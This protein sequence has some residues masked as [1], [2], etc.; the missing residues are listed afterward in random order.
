M[1]EIRLAV[2]AVLIAAGMALG[3]SIVSPQ[4][5]LELDEE[6][7]AAASAA[8]DP[9]CQIASVASWRTHGN[10]DWPITDDDPSDGF[11]V[12]ETRMG[13]EGGGVEQVV[14]TF[15]VDISSSYTPGQIQVDNG[16]SVDSET[17][18]PD[19]TELTIDV[20]GSVNI[21]AYTFDLAGSVPCLVGPATFVIRACECNF[22]GD[23]FTNNI[24]TSQVRA[25]RCTDPGP[26]TAFLDVIPDGHT[27][28]TDI[29]YTA[30]SNGTPCPGPAVDSVGN[31]VLSVE[32]AGSVYNAATGMNEIPAEDL[33]DTGDGTFYVDVVVTS[34]DPVG[35]S[36]FG[37]T[38]DSNPE[39]LAYDEVLYVDYAGFYSQFSTRFYGPEPGPNNYWEN[40][41]AAGIAAGTMPMLGPL[42]NPKEEIGTIN[43][44]DNIPMYDWHFAVDGLASWAAVAIPAGP[45]TVVIGPAYGTQ[46]YV[47][48]SEYRPMDMTVIPLRILTCQIASVASWKTHANGPWPVAGVHLDDPPWDPAIWLVT[49]SRT[50]FNDPPQQIVITFDNPAPDLAGAVTATGGLSID[51]QT[52]SPDGLTL[53]LDVSGAANF[54]SYTIDLSAALPDCPA[55]SE[56]IVVRQ[57]EG[58]T[59]GD[60]FTNKIDFSQVAA[61]NGSMTD[62]S[63][64]FMDINLDGS[65]NTTDKANVAAFNGWPCPGPAVD[66]VG[67]AV[68]SVETAGSV[69]NPAT[70]M[71]EILAEDLQDTGD[72]TF[73]VDIVV[74]SNDPVGMSA[75]G[76]TLDSNPEKLAY[77]EVTEYDYAGF[78]SN[79]SSRP[80]MPNNY[81]GNL[82][83]AR[84]SGGTMPMPGPTAYGEIGT[85]NQRDNVPLYYFH[86][87]VDGLASWVAVAI[88][89]GP[90]S[91]VIGPADGTPVYVGNSEYRP[92][93]MSVIPLRILTCQIASV[94]SIKEHANGFWA[95][96][97]NAAPWLVTES[98]TTFNDPPQQIVITF[99]NPAPDLAG[100][101]TA[102]GGL[103]IDGQALSGDG[104][105]LTLDVSG[106]A[107]FNSYTIDLSAALPD[108]P[109]GSEAIILRQCQCNTNRDNVIS[110]TDKAQVAASNG[111]LAD[112]NTAFMDVNLDGNI[113]N[114]DKS[115]VAAL[116]G[117]ACPAP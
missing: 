13:W 61:A 35:M 95:I 106:A 70:G 37:I 62:A 14:V 49:E 76:I 23:G 114:T 6:G 113:N 11:V 16:L 32:T 46:V 38:L 107:N 88:P 60:G 9:T 24:D 3:Q 104:L 115:A 36:A 17:L 8:I 67:N 25:A 84:L 55:G 105:T 102:T 100:T 79:Y 21:T 92:M 78:F 7:W 42:A 72:G 33:Q 30:Q 57:C 26:T 74:T 75:F 5:D 44:P 110:G 34:D 65:I 96:T 58:N 22:N 83:A 73:Y 45:D 81:W 4:L 12:T 94:A 27:C 91:V 51:N 85:P 101:V 63:N 64:A 20:S 69:Y 97:D 117:T 77:D 103:S 18:S 99:D 87:A 50:T 40:L 1:S 31:A 47:G 71:N 48:T 28:V 59:N 52:L 98:R 10:G 111:V 80:G 29:S 89:A 90:D 15:D 109:A 93:D 53:T 116:N 66:S 56:V 112:G 19:G 108:C 41:S 68:L 39:K 2:V 43:Q 54:N 86:F 82:N